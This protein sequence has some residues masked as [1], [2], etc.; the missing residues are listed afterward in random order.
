MPSQRYT[1][2]SSTNK[3]VNTKGNASLKFAFRSLPPEL[4][5]RIYRILLKR[6]TPLLLCDSTHDHE[7]ADHGVDKPT[8]ISH[9]PHASKSSFTPPS[10]PI[11]PLILCA[12]RLLYLESR[13]IL[14]SE[15]SF[16]LHIDSA[17]RTL[18]SLHQRSRKLIRFID[19]YIPS[20]YDV[21]DKFPDIIRL[22]LR[23]CEGLKTLVINLPFA[24]PRDDP[25]S[26]TSR[27]TVFA[28]SFSIIRWLPKGTEVRLE[29]IVHPDI[30]AV[31][32]KHAA[33]S[34]DVDETNVR[35]IDYLSSSPASHGSRFME[36]AD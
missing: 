4:R 6:D 26:I 23:Y 9:A 28:S 5:L 30:K 7:G 32:D 10:D 17:I 1:L 2:R 18:S 15:N 21:L 12:S 8:P 25:Q 33:D 3:Q 31:V 27:R 11:N 24:I 20:H 35:A 19:L 16:S 14:Y 34:S 29:G 36:L 22:G 13:P